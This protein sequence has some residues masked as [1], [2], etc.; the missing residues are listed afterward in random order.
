MPAFIF[1]SASSSTA[2]PILSV[3]YPARVVASDSPKSNMFLSPSMMPNTPFSSTVF[4]FG[5]PNNS[6]IASFDFVSIVLSSTSLSTTVLAKAFW[7]PTFAN[8]LPTAVSICP[9]SSALLVGSSSSMSTTSLAV[10][11]S[12]RSKIV[13]MS[14]FNCSNSALVI[15]DP[16]KSSIIPVGTWSAGSYSV[17]KSCSLGG[18]FAIYSSISAWFSVASPF[19]LKDESKGT[20]PLI[21]F[22]MCCI[23]S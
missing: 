22:V 11:G 19:M 17:Y 23:M 16:P 18:N 6:L 21:M 9:L 10:T 8:S 20:S 12:P 4:P 3:I 5:S 1:P 15:S 14:C 13:F 7:L 2:V